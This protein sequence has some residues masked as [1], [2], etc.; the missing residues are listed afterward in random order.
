MNMPAK[1][2]KRLAQHILLDVLDKRWKN[3]RAEL[4]RCQKEFSNEAVHDLRVAARRLLALIELLNFIE[5]RPRLQKLKRAFKDQLN[6]FD[7][8]RDTQVLLAEVAET[9]EQFPRLKKF[10]YHLQSVED[11]LLKKLRK[12]MKVVDLFDVSKRMR[13]TRVALAS[14]SVKRLDEQILS[15]IDETFLVCQQRYRLVD[16][17]Q[18][19]TIHRL[20]VAFKAFRYSVEIAYPLLENY[21]VGLFKQMHDYQSLMGE[22]QDL[23]VITKSLAEFPVRKSAA[24][25]EPILAYYQERHSEAI[26]AF[27]EDM[28]QIHTFWRS[29][30]EDSFP[31]EK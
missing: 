23:E 15:A 26:S 1:N 20:R 21:P 14:S 11:E 12:K 7:D 18:S 4:K 16:A 22:V 6:E 3:Y 2:E 8:L 19:A 13:K 5:P 27:I 24:D 25:F 31:W 10:Q 9:I 28:N 17:L 29:T 30:P